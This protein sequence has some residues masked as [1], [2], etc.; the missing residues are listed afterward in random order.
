MSPS[1]VLFGKEIPR[2]AVIGFAA[3]EGE[4]GG[5]GAGAG[6]RATGLGVVDDG[7]HDGAASRQGAGLLHQA[8]VVPAQ[9]AGFTT[10]IGGGVGHVGGGATALARADRRRPGPYCW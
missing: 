9:L 8:D 5:V 7:G 1:G 2:Y 6:L 10:A 4:G 3:G